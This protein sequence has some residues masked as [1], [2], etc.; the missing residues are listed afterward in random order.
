MAT[1]VVFP[2]RTVVAFRFDSLALVVRIRN[3]WRN[4]GSPNVEDSEHRLGNL[5][6]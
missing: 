1:R 2:Y 4:T 3:P 5:M 6:I